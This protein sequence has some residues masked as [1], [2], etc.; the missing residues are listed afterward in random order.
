MHRFANACFWS[1]IHSSEICPIQETTLPNTMVDL[2]K[3][4]VDLYI[5]MV[6]LPN[7]MVD[8]PNPW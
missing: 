7:A 6:D 3:T 4:M 5:A 2:P 1:S 8:P